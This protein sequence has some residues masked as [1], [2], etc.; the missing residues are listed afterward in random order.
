MTAATPTTTI[1]T[2]S[3]FKLDI[4]LAEP[5]DETLLQEF[6]K[7][8]PAEELRFRFIPV[9]N[10]R[11]SLGDRFRTFLAFAGDEI[12]SAGMLARDAGMENA[13][14]VVALDH[15]WHGKG[16]GATV[17]EY[18]VAEARRRGVKVLWS[19]ETPAN[20]SGMKAAHDFGFTSR[21]IPGDPDWMQLEMRL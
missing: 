16:I 21:P 15:R 1:K 18:C 2:R 14:V 12:V 5:S 10:D 3:G 8:P 20:Q 6:L 4:R 9:P 11:L 7:G 17:L 19:V 13:E